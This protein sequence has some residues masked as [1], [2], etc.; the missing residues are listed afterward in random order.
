MSSEQYL[1]YHYEYVGKTTTAGRDEIVPYW[2]IKERYNAGDTPSLDFTYTSDS[3]TTMVIQRNYFPTWA[4]TMDDKE[5]VLSP[6][7][8]G[9]ISLPI[10][11]GAH[12]YKIFQKS[13]TVQKI[14]NIITILTLLFCVLN[15]H[16]QKIKPLRVKS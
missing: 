5:V 3:N 6:T 1:K 15:I 9:E 7:S 4:A 12:T 13:T 16:L 11:S 8:T 14:G 2:A 10:S